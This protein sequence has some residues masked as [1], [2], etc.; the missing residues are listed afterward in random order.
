M[1]ADPPSSGTLSAATPSQELPPTF[2]P[3]E[4]RVLIL[5]G[6]YA[7]VATARC[8]LRRGYPASKIHLV[9]KE[10]A[11]TFRTEL[12]KVG[13]AAGGPEV[14]PPW[15][16]PFDR[17][18]LTSAGV[19]FHQGEVLRVDL[20][21]REV[22]TPSE[23]APYDLLVLSLGCIPAYYGIPGCQENSEEVY[24]VAG[25]RHLA[26]RLSKLLTAP[27]DPSDA[28]AV[29]PPVSVLIAGGGATGVELGAHIATAPWGSLLGAST[30]PVKVTVLSGPAPFLAGLPE[31]LVERAR[32]EVAR[33]G[34]EVVDGGQVISVSPG[35]VTFKDLPPREPDLFVWCGG[36]RA[37]DLIASLPVALG[38]ARRARVTPFLE[39][40]GHPGVFALGDCAAML[41]PYDGSPVPSTAQAALEQAPVAARN[42]LARIRGTKFQIF[43][44]EPRGVAIAVGRGK[45]VAAVGKRVVGGRLAGTIKSLVAKEYHAEVRGV[46]A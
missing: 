42:I 19:R 6:G 2:D 13:E 38:P 1:T 45:A 31:R 10:P 34:V 17:V 44:Y 11:T 35:K 36:L 15:T 24:T 7:G 21:A 16:F 30:R 46:L 26:Q 25:A 22:E 37:P 9:D 41:D 43:H 32:R 33:A 40:E 5:G 28:R 12:Y 18:A 23:K 39:V 20:A 3:R 27:P 4:G 14:V 8:L 29:I